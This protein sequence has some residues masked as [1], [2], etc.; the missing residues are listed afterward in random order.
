[1]EKL[2]LATLR[3]AQILE[4][5][6]LVKTIENFKGDSSWPAKEE[7]LGTIVLHSGLAGSDQYFI[8]ATAVHR[9]A[10]DYDSGPTMWVSSDPRALEL[11]GL[12]A[13]KV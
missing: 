8:T 9:C 12:L 5:D 1:M 11:A 2:R 4:L 10:S 3:K 7:I 13:K 6:R